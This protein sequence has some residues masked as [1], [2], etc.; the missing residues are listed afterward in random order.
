MI[1]SLDD[2]VPS[3]VSYFEESPDPDSPNDHNDSNDPSL[4]SLLLQHNN[5]LSSSSTF[6]E[7]RRRLVR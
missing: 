7:Q 3:S 1:A 5:S 6:N 2:S 4:P